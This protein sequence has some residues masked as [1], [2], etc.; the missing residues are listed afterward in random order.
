[1]SKQKGAVAGEGEAIPSFEYKINAKV[2]AQALSF[3][4]SFRVHDDYI[5][6]YRRLAELLGERPHLL[7]TFNGKTFLF[8]KRQ[9]KR[10]SYL[11]DILTE[12]LP[13]VLAWIVSDTMKRLGFNWPRSKINTSSIQLAKKCEHAPA[14]RKLAKLITDDNLTLS[15]ALKRVKQNL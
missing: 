2:R 10:E 15:A 3:D 8:V 9:K 5:H 12:K 1:M 14:L 4:P 6:I 7:F 13:G 11:V